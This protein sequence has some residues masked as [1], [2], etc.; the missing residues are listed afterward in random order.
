MLK[1]RQYITDLLNLSYLLGLIK[2]HR[3]LDV[4]VLKVAF[5]SCCR[6]SS[7]MQ[8]CNVKKTIHILL[9]LRHSFCSYLEVQIEHVHARAR[10]HTHT[11][12]HT[13]CSRNAQQ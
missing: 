1:A 8:F 2:Y 3:L 11:H 4:L 10:T 9:T 6:C 5:Q 12:T 13:L 7:Y